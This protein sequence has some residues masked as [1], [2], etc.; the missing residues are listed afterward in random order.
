[1]KI[2]LSLK[3]AAFFLRQHVNQSLCFYH[4]RR[5]RITATH[6]Y[7]TFYLQLN[8]T[9]RNWE[10]QY[11]RPYSNSPDRNKWS[12]LPTAN[13]W[14]L[15]IL[16]STPATRY[17]RRTSVWNIRGCPDLWTC[18]EK[19]PCGWCFRIRTMRCLKEVVRPSF[20]LRLSTS[21]YL[22][23]PVLTMINRICRILP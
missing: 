19:T 1:M 17:K 18:P 9:S 3:L 21:I 5:I 10:W 14:R 13:L 4:T 20:G 7:S 15:T 22:L 2:S 11:Y 8:R 12:T 16:L 23:S 6:D